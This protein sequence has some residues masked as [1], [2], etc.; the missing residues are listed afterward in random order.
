MVLRRM[1]FG[2]SIL[3]LRVNHYLK[4]VR[5]RLLLGSLYNKPSNR[6]FR[7][8][9]KTI[10]HDT[11]CNL[12]RTLNSDSQPQAGLQHICNSSNLRAK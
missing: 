12:K 6:H 7:G 8:Q 3:L 11:P 5:Q 10:P 9:G 4:R 1:G 2:S